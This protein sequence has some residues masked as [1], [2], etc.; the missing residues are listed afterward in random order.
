[1][2]IFQLMSVS[3]NHFL[4]AVAVFV[5]AAAQYLYRHRYL[6]TIYRNKSEAFTF[7]LRLGTLFAFNFPNGTMMLQLFTV[8]HRIYCANNLFTASL[9]LHKSIISVQRCTNAKVSLKIISRR[10]HG[11]YSGCV[12]VLQG[13]RYTW[14]RCFK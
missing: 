3:I 9:Y 14:T 12:Q 6:I 7:Q 13:R 8:R 10:C 4:S 11:I 5:W 2:R 1:M